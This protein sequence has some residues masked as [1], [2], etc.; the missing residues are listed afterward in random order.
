MRFDL[1]NAAA[2]VT[3][4]VSVKQ[5]HSAAGSRQSGFKGHRSWFVDVLK[6]L[7]RRSMRRDPSSSLRPRD[8]SNISDPI[9]AELNPNCSWLLLSSTFSEVCS[10]KKK[11][12]E[13][14]L[15][16]PFPVT[17]TSLTRIL[18]KL[19]RLFSVSVAEMFEFWSEAVWVQEKTLKSAGVFVPLS[20]GWWF[21]R[22]EKINTNSKMQ[23]KKIVFLFVTPRQNE[24][25]P[26]CRINQKRKI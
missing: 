23:L 4:L 21:V 25:K 20:W 5:T 24:P 7:T 17:V 26:G 22:H 8:A 13:P 18:E 10:L 3:K 11:L 12:S 15:G 16:F 9:A 14:K 2:D 6:H 1:V 19:N